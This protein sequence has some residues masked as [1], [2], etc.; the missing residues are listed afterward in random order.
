MSICLVTGD[1]SLDGLVKLV[2][3]GFSIVKLLSFP[4]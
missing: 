2:S 3:A 1:A 4:L